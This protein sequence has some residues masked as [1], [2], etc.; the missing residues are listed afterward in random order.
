LKWAV[1]AGL[2]LIAVRTTDRMNSKKVIEFVT[3]RKVVPLG[4][5]LKEGKILLPGEKTKVVLVANTQKALLPDLELMYRMAL[6]AEF[7]ILCLRFKDEIPEE[8][9]DAGMLPT[10]RE[11]VFKTL[12]DVLPE[13]EVAEIIP[14]LGGMTL[15]EVGEAVR[16]TMAR[17]G[18]V[19]HQGLMVTRKSLFSAVR[20]ISLVDTN[21]PLYWPQND[22]A[23]FVKGNKGF[24]LEAPDPRLRPRGLLLKGVPGTG[25]TA[26]A[27]Y[28]ATQWGVPL[29]RMD[30]TVQNKYVGQSEANF[31]TALMQ[32]DQE[33]PCVLLV[34]EVEKLFHS[35]GTDSSGV[36]G[37][38]LGQF[39]WWLQEHQSRVF[40]V[41]T[42]NNERIIPPELYRAG[43]VDAQVVFSGLK[44]SEAIK[45][46]EALVDTFQFEI[47]SAD[48][49]KLAADQL[50][51]V[52]NAPK[53]W[54]KAAGVDNEP[55]LAHAFIA[56]LVNDVMKAVLSKEALK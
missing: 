56:K 26:G 48:P 39:L 27:K 10:P 21:M 25:K 19:S 55:E 44:Q 22:I 8:F 23:S 38:M 35:S 33:E 45:F 24:F 6:A 7:S 36:T 53:T 11:L 40:T 5:V 2:P 15:R 49:Y 32:V 34:D 28:I 47:K 50:K 42:C 30:A 54:N 9:F 52:F 46:A 18:S 31:A 51:S 41:M 17:D 13:K 43:R 1:D 3:K 20:G 37:K 4:D 29:Y 16:L 14:A 12:A